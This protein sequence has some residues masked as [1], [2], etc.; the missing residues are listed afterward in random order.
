MKRFLVV[1]AFVLALPALAQS[2]SAGQMHQRFPAS[3]D[4]TLTGQSASIGT[5]SIVGTASAGIYHVCWIQQITR[6]A[7]VSSSL[8]TTVGW[9]NGSAKST[10]MLS[11]N[12]GLL[13]LTADATNLLN[14]TGSSC[15]MI[16]SAD[17][18]A[19][20]YSTTYASVGGTTMLYGFY[21]T[22]ERLQ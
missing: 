20:T 7:S 13:Q 2:P 4:V 18:Q 10:T 6:V 12:G 9:N 8:I 21:V 15:I 1:V 5:T 11:L 14:S 3:A 16:F 17:G 19:I 22:A